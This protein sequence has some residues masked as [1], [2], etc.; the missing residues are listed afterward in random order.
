MTQAQI[1]ECTGTSERTIRRLLHDDRF[2][3]L[4]HQ[5]RHERTDEL[6][7]KI[8]DLFATALDELR[9]LMVSSESDATRLGAIRTVIGLGSRLE[10]EQ[11]DDRL[12][13]LEEATAEQEGWTPDYLPDEDPQDDLPD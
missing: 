7:A 13:R 3:R 1:R 5:A 2:R 4:V 6:N 10:A 8:P 12:D 11:F 9:N